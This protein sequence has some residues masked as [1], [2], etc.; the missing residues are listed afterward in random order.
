M[1][2]E[3]VLRRRSDTRMMGIAPSSRR[4]RVRSALSCRDPVRR[5]D[6]QAAALALEPRFASRRKG[7]RIPRARRPR[8]R[9][10]TGRIE[11]SCSHATYLAY[12]ASAMEVAVVVVGDE[13]LSGH[14]QDANAA[15]IATRVAHHGHHLRRVVIVGDDPDQIAA[16]LTLDLA[17]PAE[18]I[19]VC[20]GLGP[21][22]DDRTMEGVAAALGSGLEPASGLAERIEDIVASV[23]RAGFSQSAFGVDGLRKMALAPVG[24]SILPSSGGVI[25]AVTVEHAGKRI[26]I[27]PGPPRELQM[28]FTEAVE[29]AYL[30]G[31]GISVWREEL[32]HRF[33]ESTF[34]L[35]LTELQ[36]KFSSTSIGSYPQRDHT[37]I[38][39]AGPRDEAQAVAEELRAHLLT[40]SESDEGR[41][42]LDFMSTRRHDGA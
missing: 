23:G 36:T 28:V 2:P 42:L 37:L 3:S 22:H 29:P 30:E 8:A 26:V 21:T 20:G 25:P 39:I 19:C 13:I 38:R 27:L 34:A 10:R 17:S 14:V 35:V 33:P 18:L 4:V 40:F 12:P 32:T 7:K 15:F 31:T 41:R 1:T 5:T 24:A 9:S 11:R 16:E 6:F